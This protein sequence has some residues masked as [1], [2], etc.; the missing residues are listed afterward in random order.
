MQLTVGDNCNLQKKG[1]EGKENKGKRREK[2]KSKEK[3]DSTQ[4]LKRLLEHNME[5]MT[6]IHIFFHFPNYCFRKWNNLT[7]Q[8]YVI[9]YLP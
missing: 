1:K 3:K 6:S 2:Q 5:E 8:K 7:S 4:C 9:T